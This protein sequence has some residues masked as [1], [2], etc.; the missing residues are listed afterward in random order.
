MQRGATQ[1]AKVN[2][3]A[4]VFYDLA[5]DLYLV[6]VGQCCIPTYSKVLLMMINNNLSFRATMHKYFF[7]FHKLNNIYFTLVV[8]VFFSCMHFMLKIH[9]QITKK[10]PKSKKLDQFG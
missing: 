7:Y 2:D 9:T 4:L 6:Q 1:N 8:Y 10:G 3:N 5:R